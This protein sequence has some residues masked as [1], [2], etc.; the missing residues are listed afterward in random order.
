M[1]NFFP[2]IYTGH[3]C[4]SSARTRVKWKTINL[5]MHEWMT[6]KLHVTFQFLIMFPLFIVCFN[7]KGKLGT[8]FG[9]H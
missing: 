3:I 8:P 1:L 4:N 9:R 6:Y 2:V 5:Q 7:S